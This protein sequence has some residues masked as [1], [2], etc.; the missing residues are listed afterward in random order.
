MKL[1]SEDRQCWIAIEAMADPDGY[2][3][4]AVEAHADIGH[5]QF[6]AKNADVQFLNLAQFVAEFDRFL[7]DRSLSPRLEGT[8]GCYLAFS[9]AGNSVTVQYGIGDAFC[10]KRTVYFQQSGAFEMAQENLLPI[11]ADFRR[12][13]ADGQQS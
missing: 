10:G 9:A 2:C 6:C 3:G 13:V 1:T 8:Y 5:G 4:F 7:L 11:L 12:I